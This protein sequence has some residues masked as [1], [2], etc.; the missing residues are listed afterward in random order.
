MAAERAD[1]F[2]DAGD[3]DGS[4]VWKQVLKAVK[5]IQRQEPREGDAQH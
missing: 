3:S 4:A 5:E 2:L 1:S